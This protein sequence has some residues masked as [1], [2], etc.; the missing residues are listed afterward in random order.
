MPWD[1]LII[2]ALICFIFGMVAGILLVR[3]KR[4]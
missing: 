2:S 4:S 1:W 3:P